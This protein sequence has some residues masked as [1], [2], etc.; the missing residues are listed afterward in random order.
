MVLSTNETGFQSRTA[1]LWRKVPR[2]ERALWKMVGTVWPFWSAQVSCKS[3]SRRRRSARLAF[4]VTSPTLG[5]THV[6]HLTFYFGAKQALLKALTLS[7]SRL[8]VTS[9]RLSP[10]LGSTFR[11][12]PPPGF[13]RG[14]QRLLMEAY[15]VRLM[16]AMRESRLSRV[17]CACQ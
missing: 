4:H 6:R 9:P 2:A 3:A 11:V 17:L 1:S 13:T 7:A 8:A 15:N 12:T 10:T 5:S 14:A 16:G